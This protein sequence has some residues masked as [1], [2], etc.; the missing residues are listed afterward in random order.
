M[1]YVRGEPLDAYLDGRRR[2]GERDWL[3]TGLHLLR[4]AAAALAH[5]HLR[6]ILHLD[7]K[8]QNILVVDFG[9]ER[10]PQ[11]I[12]IDFGLVRPVTATAAPP[13][14]G[15]A[16][17]M[18][19][20]LFRGEAPGPAYDVYSLGVTFYR[21]L[22][23]RLPFSA[24]S[25]EGYA[26][27]HL[28]APPPPLPELPT[29]LAGLV[30]RMLAKD[31]ALRF[32]DAG[33]LTGALDALEL[34]G[35][36]PPA[37]PPLFHPPEFA[38]RKKELKAFH[39]WLQAAATDRPP[40]VVEGTTGS[41]KS[42]LLGRFETILEMEGHP[43]LRLECRDCEARLVGELLRSAS[44]LFGR[45]PARTPEDRLLLVASGEKQPDGAT[46]RLLGRSQ[47][48]ELR[49]AVV[50]LAA[51]RIAGLIHG[52][53]LFVLLD[54]LHAAGAQG[55]E[56]FIQLAGALAAPK[57]GAAGAFPSREGE[58]RRPSSPAAAGGVL[59]SVPPTL[60]E[61]LAGALA[62]RS[63]QAQWMELGPLTAAETAGL[64]IAGLRESLA[65]LPPARVRALKSQLHRR[66]GGNPLFFLQGLLS[67]REGA[68]SAGPLE[69]SSRLR[70][71]IATL[72]PEEKRLLV[73][74]S[75]LGR[76]APATELGA[77][78]G[79]S[80]RET[81]SRLRRL[82]QTGL[83]T[84]AIDAARIVH[85]G[86]EAAVRESASE[87]EIAAG[88]AAIAAHLAA[89]TETLAPAAHHYFMAGREE[90]GVKAARELLSTLPAA[91]LEWGGVRRG[92]G[93]SRVL[94]RAAEASPDG[95]NLELSF[96]EAAGDVL[97]AEGR[98]GDCLEARARVAAL[99][100][101]T[102]GA[103]VEKG[104][105]RRPARRGGRPPAIRP[106]RQ[107]ASALHR[108]GKISAAGALLDDCLALLE[109]APEIP[110]KIQALAEKALLCHFRQQSDQALELAQEGLNLW[111]KLP[112][113]KRWQLVQPALNLH[114]IVGQIHIRRLESAEAI[115]WLRE[116]VELARDS[117]S[118]ANIAILLNNLGLA[119]HMANRLRDALRTF[120]RA[121]KAARAA[122]DGSALVSIF[123]NLAQIRAKTGRFTAAREALA[124]A[125][126]IAAVEQSLRLRLGHAYSH[127]M[128][129]SLLG[130]AD[131][132]AW[133]RVQELAGQVGDQFLELCAGIFRAEALIEHGQLGSARELLAGSKKPLLAGARLSRLAYI[134]A[135]EGNAGR[136]RRLRGR[137]EGALDPAS[138]MLEDWNRLFLGAAAAETAEAEEARR[139]C[140]TAESSFRAA[141]A[142]AGR[143][144]SA[145]RL[146]DLALRAGR[147]R[148]A[149]RWLR[150]VRSLPAEPFAGREPRLRD[151]RL[152][153]LQ[154]RGV[155]LS[156]ASGKLSR[157]EA[158]ARLGDLL[159]RAA[160]DASLANRPFLEL[161][162]AM[163][164]A[165]H[166]EL[167][168]DMQEARRSGVR[169]R[170]LQRQLDRG[171]ARRS[172]RDPW[173]ALGLEAFRPPRGSLRTGPGEAKVLEHL[174]RELERADDPSRALAAGLGCLGEAA[175]ARET[176]LEVRSP[177]GSRQTLVRWPERRVSRRVA[178]ASGGREITA[179]LRCLSTEV[180]R[181]RVLLPSSSRLRG[182]Q[183]ALIESAA[184][185]M[186][187][188]CSLLASPAAVPGE[189]AGGVALP[190][191]RSSPP[192]SRP[193][194][195]AETETLER[196]RELRRDR[197]SAGPLR[198]SWREGFV[199]E[200]RELRRV[201]LVVERLRDSD[202]PVLITGES[203]T[204]KDHVA[205]LI[206]RTSRRAKRPFLTQS[207]SALSPELLEA[208]LFGY[209]RGAF[210]GADHTH[211]GFL[212]QAQGG[213]FH[214]EEIGDVPSALQTR[215]L[216][217]IEEKAVRPLG[218][219]GSRPLDV[220]FIVSTH[221]DI[222]SLVR[223]GEFRK[224]LFYRLNGARIHIPPLRQHPED[225]PALIK[226]HS[227]D[228]PEGA[229][230][231]SSAALEALARHSW[232][233]NVRELMTVL[234]RLAIEHGASAVTRGDVEQA[235]GPSPRA[236]FFGPALFASRPFP[237][238][239]RL[240]EE[241]Y[242]R[243]LLE[244]H[245]GNLEDVARE[246]GTS[247]RSV[248]RRFERLG[249]KPG[250]LGAEPE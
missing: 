16:P 30:L 225:I 141:G 114:G 219:S 211:T 97:E 196:T 214:L 10:L 150:L 158:A 248:Y 33:E 4:Q 202:L 50:R 44:L 120:H 139:Y 41:G 1:E 77:M 49:Q 107:L 55:R 20:E 177:E 164:R 96:L 84:P 129:Q 71:E 207:C 37:S 113:R 239:Q 191:G 62:A 53:G 160:G 40:L 51:E 117:I 131:D 194:R 231:L 102:S 229:V 247:T 57:R 45:P 81:A 155:L 105:V 122:E 151:L 163:L 18:A 35:Q 3:S 29:P 104:A 210:S 168:D 87:E 140:L 238:I 203:G 52:A 79:L 24:Q 118:S 154:A 36:L 130:A 188:L 221:R 184:R 220:R 222:E 138:K 197:G 246:L 133:S 165:A 94:L 15:T 68:G 54:D 63:S 8:P 215:L 123:C 201:L 28:S 106:L 240:L 166:A 236:E 38:G 178:T 159:A 204:G 101:L 226:L 109:E 47:A 206:H 250:Q 135:L 179:P 89:S 161:E 167:L 145:L 25:I 217:F 27:A 134:E 208:D 46:R 90:E 6:G 17:Y 82:R 237:E 119:Y 205:R 85:E 176:R 23:G 132:A 174:L 74:I 61:P 212:F 115:R 39:A 125:G 172:G 95:S 128:V 83:L 241:S 98:Y 124:S 190:H 245:R 69:L 192:P 175:G 13:T 187:P 126:A 26:R 185:A 88:H 108:A 230:R 86:V 227:R 76:P 14:R 66:T 19:P 2:P 232:P 65:G 9:E 193:T 181:L 156:A 171:A 182:D 146:A 243:Y 137:Y 244:K 213:T 224:D 31:P 59:V 34:P 21:V 43:V 7:I 216:R 209:R 152:A 183:V 11:P 157:E 148:E 103:G 242:L 136:S 234:R 58:R 144:E 92:G 111:K 180:G 73:A 143:L 162:L 60:R 32:R 153:I 121:E 72:D 112:S 67:L 22:T 249:L 64:E 223:R 99:L 189:D 218:A 199:A 56:F 127:A 200:S 93:V 12:L 198:A 100:G 169:A 233:G 186:A 5:I 48:V 149:Q 228:L 91:S 42:R 110:E 116:G 170:I 142:V 173:S 80:L 195:E 147:E 235:L 70:E 75:A 78:L